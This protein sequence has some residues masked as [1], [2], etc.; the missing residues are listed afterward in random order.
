M[1]DWV[2]ECWSWVFVKKANGGAIASIGSSG[3]GGVN[4][5]D[6]NDNSIP[7]CIEGL[8]GWFETQFFRLY[9]EEHLDFLGE[10]YSQV[11]TDYVNSF[12]VYTDRYDAKII[13]THILLGDPSLKIGG[14]EQ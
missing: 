9:N 1:S 4:I 2:P 13:Q 6:Y 8:D 14:Y 3:Y 7:D 12:P 5:G 10:T 11:I